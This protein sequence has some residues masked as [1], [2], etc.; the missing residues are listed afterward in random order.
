MNMACVWVVNMIFD[1]KHHANLLAGLQYNQN[2]TSA[3]FFVFFGGFV[4]G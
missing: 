4:S 2:K 3:Q 1:H